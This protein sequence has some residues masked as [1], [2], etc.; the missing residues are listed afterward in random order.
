MLSDSFIADVA[1][2]IVSI[3]QRMYQKGFVA[4]NDGNISCRLDEN[5][6]LITPTGVSKGFLDASGMVLVRLDG[7]VISKNA[8]PSC[9]MPMHL[10]IYRANSSIGAITH[11][12]P[13]YSTALGIAGF[14]LNDSLLPESVLRLHDVPLLPYAT[15]G[16]DALP[17]LIVP[18]CEKTRAV[19]LQNHGAVTWGKDLQDAFFTM[20]ALEHTAQIQLICEHLIGKSNRISAEHMQ[21]LK[22]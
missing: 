21:E 16:T 13:P 1:A 19:L 18:H 11:A 12:H 10:R 14:T 20:E 17:D 4:A 2:Q 3:G 6:I 9:E 5:T 22:G 8:A 15:P 7:T